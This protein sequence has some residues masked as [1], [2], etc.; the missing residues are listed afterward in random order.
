MSA[1][2]AFE[3]CLYCFL[4][5]K[6]AGAFFVSGWRNVRKEAAILSLYPLS[7]W[8][9]LKKAHTVFTGKANLHYLLVLCYL[10]VM[11]VKKTAGL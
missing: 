5:I 2:Y 1:G 6:E 8:F 7:Y 9:P 11:E 3:V 4:Q 10:E